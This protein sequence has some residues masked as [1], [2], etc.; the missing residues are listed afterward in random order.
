M[1]LTLAIPTH[2]DTMGLRRLLAQAA[3]LG[4]FDR[5]VV[6]DDASEPPVI[7]EAVCPLGAWPAGCF[8]LLR[9]EKPMGAGYARNTALEH[10]ETEHVLFFDADDLMTPDLAALV[11]GLSERHFD[12]CM[13]KHADSRRKEWGGLGQMPLDEAHWRRAGVQ[14]GAIN[15]IGA[16]QAA[17]LAQT[18]NYPWNKIYRTSF[19]QEHGIR[20][21]ETL[22]HNDLELHWMSFFHGRDIL[23]SD[24]V[25]A[26]HF[27][28]SSGQRLTNRKGEER[29]AVFDP[30][31]RLATAF[32]QGASRQLMDA[33]LH[34]VSGLFDWIR[35]NIAHDLRDRLDMAVRDF[36]LAHVDEERFAWLSRTDAVLARRIVFQMERGRE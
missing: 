25:G 19:L 7:R 8:V 24:R 34:F 12:F 15:S 20:C 27:V 2:N 36:L 5:V 18:A 26:L 23:V 21:S 30:L 3:V 6:V 29:L 32:R 1:M 14:V 22:V 17:A 10:V 31:D 11:S 4:V 35:C 28:A 16:V 13:F 9:L 33:F